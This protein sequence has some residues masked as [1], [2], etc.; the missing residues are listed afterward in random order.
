MATAER[1]LEATIDTGDGSD[2][3]INH[4]SGGTVTESTNQVIQA[5]T[6]AV[7]SGTTYTIDGPGTARAPHIIRAT[8]SGTIA[9]TVDVSGKGYAKVGDR[10]GRGVGRGIRAGSHTNGKGGGGGFFG[11]NGGGQSGGWAQTIPLYDILRNALTSLPKGGGSGAGEGQ[12]S[13]SGPV[14]VVVAP[15]ILASG[16]IKADGEDGANIGGTTG[17]PGGGSGGLVVLIG[18]NIDVSNIV[19]STLG[20]AGGSANGDSGGSGGNGGLVMLYTDSYTITGATLPS[21]VYVQQVTRSVPFGVP[22]YL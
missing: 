22:L 7:A 2:G 14:L 6:W 13:A 4:N 18:E 20:G 19:I 8:E 15:T 17:G 5:T 11:N 9:G 21:D 1:Y 16:I 3:A 10:F 12:G